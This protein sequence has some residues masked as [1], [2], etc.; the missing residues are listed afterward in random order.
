M[1][2][3]RHAP[4]PYAPY[5]ADTNIHRAGAPFPAQISPSGTES[6]FTQSLQP[7]PGHTKFFEPLFFGLNSE[8]G[9]HCP[10]FSKTPPLA[11]KISP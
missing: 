6:P 2:Y 7:T 5:A 9:R 11:A 3:A 8:K 1:I 10:I 4:E